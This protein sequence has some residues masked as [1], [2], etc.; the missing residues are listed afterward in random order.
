MAL[1]SSA[2]RGPGASS[3]RTGRGAAEGACRK[4]AQPPGAAATAR[5]A[6]QGGSGDCR[7]QRRSTSRAAYGSAPPQLGSGRQ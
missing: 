5:G 3:D 7:G 4:R 1:A 6:G 2:G